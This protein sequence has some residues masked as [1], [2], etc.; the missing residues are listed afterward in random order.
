MRHFLTD[1]FLAL[2]DTITRDEA[3][4][5]ADKL[6]IDGKGLYQVLPEEWYQI[7]DVQGRTI[8][9]Q[10]QQSEYGPVRFLFY[11]NLSLFL[12][13]ENMINSIKASM[14]SI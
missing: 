9:N 10:L 11:L 5:M 14:G 1:F 2:D 3:A 13:Y 7:Y 8:Y 6:A 12:K 4:D